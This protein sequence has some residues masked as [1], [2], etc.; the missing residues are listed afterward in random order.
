M[1]EPPVGSRILAVLRTIVNLKQGQVE[2]AAGYPPGS[3]SDL[4]RRQE[5]APDELAELVG[6][7][8]GIPAYMIRPTRDLIEAVDA[9]RD[10]ARACDPEEAARRELDDRAYASFLDLV[11]RLDAL[12]EALMEHRE[13]PYLWRHLARHTP[14]ERLAL[15]QIDPEFWSPGLCVL[16]CEKSAEAAA[17]DG[18]KAEEHSRLAL[19]I[20][21]RVPGGAARRARLE[22]WAEL[23]LGN[24]LR[25]RG[26]LL[27][28]DEAFTRS[29]VLWDQGTGTFQ[30]LLD[31]SRP[32]D[33]KASLRLAQRRLPESLELLERAAFLAPTSRARGRI[34][35]KKAK[36]LEELGDTEAALGVLREVEPHV[37]Q[38][39]D[40]R[41][42]LVLTFNRLVL[43]CDLGRAAEASLGLNE[44]KLLA[45][46]LPSELERVRFRWLEGRVAAGIGRKEEAMAAYREVGEAFAR[47]DI[48]YDNALVHLELSRHLLEEGRTAEVRSLTALLEP[49]FESQGV[50]REA[51]A[52]LRLFVDAARNDE[53]TVAL[54]ASV[55]DFLRR[56]RHNAGVH[57]PALAGTPSPGAAREKGPEK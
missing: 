20:A 5:P 47:L 55:L 54:A 50:H 13:A 52:A 25:V 26:Q 38:A 22:G 31:P 15:V 57:F 1:A 51:L 53:A 11:H 48:P 43:L 42:L 10:P 6:A 8:M 34:L 27:A 29:D 4:E 16:V 7:G 19:E 41:Q 17:D 14:A 28:A 56:S 33:L 44:V 24:A 40:L 21:R 49:V 46:R 9:A 36:A 2:S 18:R 12:A 23:F 35:L 37:L 30:E 3:L 32:L 45:H 39:G